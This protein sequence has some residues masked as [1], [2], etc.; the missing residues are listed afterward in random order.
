MLDTE[1]ENI[2]LSE[3]IDY[4]NKGFLARNYEGDFFNEYKFI[5]NNNDEY[6]YS[7]FTLGFK[8]LIFDY[9]IYENIEIKYNINVTDINDNV[10]NY[11]FEIG[12]NRKYEEKDTTKEEIIWNEITKEEWMKYL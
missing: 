6:Y 2:V 9:N 7:G 11:N 12:F 1:Y 3:Y 10:F 4:N 8:K 5:I